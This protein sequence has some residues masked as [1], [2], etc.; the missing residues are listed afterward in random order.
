[1]A[2]IFI[3]Y[4][5]P[6]WHLALT[7][8]EYL[9]S[10]GWSVWWDKSLTS[11][12][13]F[14]DEIMR[15]LATAKAVIVIWTE[16]SV[17]SDCVC[18]EAGR[19]KADGKLIPVKQQTLRYSDIPLPFGEMHTEN[20]NP[21]DMALIRAAVVAQLARPPPHPAALNLQVFRYQFLTWI[22]MV[23]G[24]ITL[25]T[26]IRGI[27]D[28]ADWA[29]WV[30]THWHLWSHHVWSYL[31]GWLRISIPERIVPLLSFASF[32]LM[33]VIGTRLKLANDQKKGR[34]TKP[35]ENFGRSLPRL[36]AWSAV[37]LS[38]LCAMYYFLPKYDPSA[39]TQL[40][41]T[42]AVL[43]LAWTAP[44][45]L[46]IYFSEDRLQ[47]AFT[48]VLLVIFYAILVYIPAT[49]LNRE[50]P[51]FL[52]VVGWKAMAL[53]F[54]PAISLMAIVSFV[55]AAYISRRLSFLL[56]GTILL[57][58]FNEVSLLELRHYIWG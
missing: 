39:T 5:K 40:L 30:V 37:Y 45:L 12:E 53:Y 13:I 6:D 18:A 54:I 44:Y 42:R 35:V 10:E 11:G 1:M 22:G 46:L 58:A 48:S 23:G 17:K 2:D 27:F 28:L 9:K 55:P 15:Q 50:A 36:L 32:T 26:N 14:R 56:V 24:T 47:V 41:L 16:R 38:F 20:L 43:L 7:L 4:A 57:F 31:F 52:R 51:Y 21:N 19:A 3:S 49:T 33:L 25:F 29:R 34:K 8:S